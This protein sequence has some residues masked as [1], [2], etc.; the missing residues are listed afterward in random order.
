MWSGWGVEPIEGNVK[1]WTDLLDHLFR[2]QDPAIRKWFEQ[3]CAYPVV[4][5]GAKLYSAC[6]LWSPLTGIGKSF[7]G[8]ILGDIYGP[9]FT[10]IGNDELFSGFNEWARYRQFIMAE[11][12]T[13]PDG[14]KR[15]EIANRMK[16]L[17]TQ[18]RVLVNEKNVPRFELKDCANWYL[19]SNEP[20]ALLLD[21]QDR[22]FFVH[23]VTG[24]KPQDSFFEAI[25]KWRD[26]PDKV[27]PAGKCRG[28]SHLLFYFL[29]GGVNLEDFKPMAAPPNTLA[30]A[31]MIVANKSE[32]DQWVA[33][34]KLD[35]TRGLRNQ[36]E[37]V[38]AK[39]D[40][41]LNAAEHCDVFTAEQLYAAFNPQER[42][43][44]GSPN[45]LSRSLTAAEFIKADRGSLIATGTPAGRQKLWIVRNHMKWEKATAEKVAQHWRDFFGAEQKRKF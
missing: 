41:K 39:S 24:P 36:Y 32:L 29:N 25:N 43:H 10:Q 40:K 19:T 26:H 16:L 27:G 3:W 22:R 42:P 11:E 1:P 15:R 13:S 17:I 38:K 12:I 28:A 34:L 23:Q 6:M 45:I 33:E 9:G 31:E 20:N 8:Y 7:A 44:R 14:N 30:K 18:E 37:Q 21:D 4:N 2:D 35:T 5:P